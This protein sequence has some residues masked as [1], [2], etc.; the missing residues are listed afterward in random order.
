MRWLLLAI[1]MASNIGANYLLKQAVSKNSDVIS[2]PVSSWL[3][4]PVLIGGLACAGLT[5]IL[6]ALTLREFP[7]SV[8]Y[9]I[10][11][12]LAFLG[13]FYLSWSSFG[14]TMTLVKLT[15]AALILCGVSLLATST[16]AGI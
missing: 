13:V 2:E 1:T 4:D 6:Y 11:S 14:E 12:S 7:L 5:L 8:A 16:N 15:G 10:V 9:Q 3:L